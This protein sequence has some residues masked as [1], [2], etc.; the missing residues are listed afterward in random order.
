[1]KLRT[2]SGV[3]IS[4]IKEGNSGKF[5]VLVHFDKPVRTIELTKD[6]S[7]RFASLLF[8]HTKPESDNGFKD[9]QN[10]RRQQNLSL[11]GR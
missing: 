7:I 2:N 9:E 1:M 11:G 8:D 4:F 10:S 3:S 6:E 5:K